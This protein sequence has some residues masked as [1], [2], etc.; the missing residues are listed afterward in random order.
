MHI[1]TKLPGLQAL[2]KNTPK[3]V[4]SV[5]D[6]MVITPTSIDEWKKPPFQRELRVT[7]RV[8]VVGQQIKEDGVIPG[9]VTLGKLG[10]DTYLLDGQHRM[11]AF[12][13]SGLDEAYM[14]TRICTFTSIGDMGEEFV[15]LNSS[16]VRMK[17][18]DILR[19]LEGS[20]E[21][22]RALRRR[23][24]FVG[25]DHLR[26]AGPDGRAK[27]LLSVTVAVRT[28]FGASM[29]T[30]TAGPSSV[31]AAK[32]LDQKETEK[33]CS[34]LNLCFDAWSGDQA[35]FKLWGSLNLV[36]LMWLYRRVVLDEG[37]KHSNNRYI[38]LNGPQFQKC[39][40]ALSVSA[41]YVDWLRGRNISDRDRPPCYTRIR[42]IFV[43]R[44]SEMDIKGARF[45]Q[46]DWTKS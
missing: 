36:L 42:D 15:R 5:M 9:I 33:L 27:T 41:M 18:D 38:K 40:M 34:F 45:P 23:C 12:R 3:G 6:T 11:E 32:A 14:D 8:V 19:G 37:G 7:P 21:F 31:E 43:R 17:N 25:Y 2:P 44:L 46:A 24:P 20:H 28:W 4:R 16:L 39:L 22:L 1:V 10:G 29:P 35:N 13:L 30:P 26:M